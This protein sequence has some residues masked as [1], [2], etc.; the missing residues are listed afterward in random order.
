MLLD[1]GSGWVSECPGRPIF[2]FFIREKWISAMIGH[3]G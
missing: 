3:A 1:V 2:I